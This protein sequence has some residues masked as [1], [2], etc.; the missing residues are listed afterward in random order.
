MNI[1]VISKYLVLMVHSKCHPG[2]PSLHGEGQRMI[3]CVSAFSKAQNL[4]NFFYHFA[5]QDHVLAKHIF[6]V[7]TA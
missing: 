5:H 1:K 3:C 2:K 6:N 4:E 7:T